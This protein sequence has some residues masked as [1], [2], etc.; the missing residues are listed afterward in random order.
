MNNTYKNC[1]YIMHKLNSFISLMED[2]FCWSFCHLSFCYYLNMK[3]WRTHWVRRQKKSQNK[4][5]NLEKKNY[6]HTQSFHIKKNK[7]NK[8]HT[9]ISFHCTCIGFFCLQIPDVVDSLQDTKTPTLNYRTIYTNV[10]RIQHYYTYNYLV[11][12]LKILY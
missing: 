5:I 2:L 1:N 10:T 9:I 4:T 7:S 11:N 8:L 3:D 6:S 12:N